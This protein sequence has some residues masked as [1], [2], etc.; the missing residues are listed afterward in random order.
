MHT[1][2]KLTLP[3]ICLAA[4]IVLGTGV[5]T[6]PPAMSYADPVVA[7]ILPQYMTAT[8]DANSL[9]G[10]VGDLAR[11]S[12]EIVS[13]TTASSVIDQAIDGK[14][15][16]VIEKFQVTARRLSAPPPPPNAK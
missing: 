5:F 3:A 1:A 4:G 11:E 9:E 7:Q 8:V 12:W 2:R 13:I 16:I 14:T 10:K 6:S 15:H